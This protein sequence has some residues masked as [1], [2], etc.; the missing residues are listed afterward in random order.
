MFD[1]IA[2]ASEDPKTIS[3]TWLKV[4]PGQLDSE[5]YRLHQF[6]TCTV[7][8]EHFFL[9]KFTSQSPQRPHSNGSLVHR[10]RQ[11]EIW[12]DQLEDG[13]CGHY[14]HQPQGEQFGHE[15]TQ[16][17]IVRQNESRWTKVSQ[18]LIVLRC[19]QRK[20]PQAGYKQLPCWQDRWK[21]EGGGSG[22]WIFM[23]IHSSWNTNTATGAPLCGVWKA[24]HAKSRNTKKAFWMDPICCRYRPSAA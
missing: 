11:M 12:R 3:V 8:F 1:E 16:P 2:H 22:K 6:T 19:T 24:Q 4:M 7:S 21:L 23:N 17:K 5:I 20:Q 15:T 13:W 18:S 9:S 14:E 10:D